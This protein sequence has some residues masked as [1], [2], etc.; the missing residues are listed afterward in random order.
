MAYIKQ[1]ENGKTIGYAIAPPS[2]EAELWFEVAENDIR[3]V[4]YLNP[5]A[6]TMTL[7]RA[8]VQV[9]TVMQAYAEALLEGAVQGYSNVERDTWFGKELESIKFTTSGDPNDAPYLSIEADAAGIPLSMI[10]GIVIAKATTLKVYTSHV[11]GNR[12]FHYR[13][14]AAYSTIEQV[15]AYDFSDG[16]IPQ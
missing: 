6:I 11:L 2:A 7:E 10:A 1:D 9:Q 8:I 14:I 3:V 4:E 15:L 5:D 12:A 16:W 13:T